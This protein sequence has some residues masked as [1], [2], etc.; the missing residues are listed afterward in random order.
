MQLQTVLCYTYMIFITIFKIKHKLY[1]ASGS[2]PTLILQRKILC[3][4]LI[5]HTAR[6]THGQTEYDVWQVRQY[7]CYG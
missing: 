4:Q 7:R 1:T 6:F 5:S 2:A 3:A